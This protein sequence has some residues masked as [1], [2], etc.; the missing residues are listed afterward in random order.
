MASLAVLVEAITVSH[1]KIA[2]RALP[3]AAALPSAN[4]GEFVSDMVLSFQ[5]PSEGFRARTMKQKG[6]A[7]SLSTQ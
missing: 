7:I 6:M 4:D 3:I 2:T 5:F 1:C